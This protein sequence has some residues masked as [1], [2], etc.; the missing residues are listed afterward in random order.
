MLT[1]L[2]RTQEYWSQIET[3]IDKQGRLLDLLKGSRNVLKNVLDVQRSY[4]A[5]I[6]R[7]PQETLTEIMEWACGDDVDLSAPL[8]APLVLSA[9]CKTWRGALKY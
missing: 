4:I 9:V 8:C 1:A 5:P 2:A 6:R 7:L 3:V